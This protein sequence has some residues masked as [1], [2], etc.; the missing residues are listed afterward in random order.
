M[1]FFNSNAFE[2]PPINNW[3]ELTEETWKG[4]VYMPSPFRS[5]SNIALMSMIIKNSDFMEA[6]YIERYGY[7]PDLS[8]DENAGKLFI[9]LLYENGVNLT[10]T[11][12]ECVE[13]LNKSTTQEPALAIM[14]SSKLRMRETGYAIQAIPD[15]TPFS[16]AYTP[17]SVSIA[18]GARNIN[19]AKLFIRWLLGEADGQGVGYIPYLQSGAWPVREDVQ[20]G[21]DLTIS[22][23]RFLY[24]DT[25]YIYESNEDILAYLAELIGKN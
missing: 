25:E 13:F 22:E 4:R 5:L 17:N 9:R 19:A 24:L 16:G 18:G 12:D 7:A 6:A 8:R 20:D 10:N 2:T 3:W 15:I 14:I 11:G 1:V 23:M 21:S